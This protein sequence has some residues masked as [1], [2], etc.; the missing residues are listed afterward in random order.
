[1]IQNLSKFHKVLSSFL[2]VNFSLKLMSIEALILSAL[3]RFLI[4]NIKFKKMHKYLGVKGKEL[5][6]NGD[7]EGYKIAREI[8][9]V[10]NKVA[11]VTPWESKCL[12]RAMTAQNMMKRRGYKTTLYL[13]VGK[14][15]D[16]MNAHSWVRYG[17]FFITGGNGQYFAKVAMFSN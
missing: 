7:I 6:F 10:V 5:S 3:Y 9:L 14:D 11:D 15:E 13:G 2:G 17:A 8:S 16:G 1:M 12:V 4:L